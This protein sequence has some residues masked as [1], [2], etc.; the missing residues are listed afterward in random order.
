LK[1]RSFIANKKIQKIEGIGPV[2]GEKFEVAGVGDTDTLL[3][4]AGTKA[5]RKAI[6]EATS[7]PSLAS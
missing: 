4:K 7:S 3:E 2:L 6:S 1:G 5:G